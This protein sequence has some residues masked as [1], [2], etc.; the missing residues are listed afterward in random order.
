MIEG[1]RE[2]I[3]FSRSPVICTD[4]S[5]MSM[6]MVLSVSDYVEEDTRTDLDILLFISMQ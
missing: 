3:L 1:Q 6:E 4:E 2:R 5:V